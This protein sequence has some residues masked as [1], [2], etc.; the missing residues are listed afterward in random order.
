MKTL[1]YWAMIVGAVVSALSSV[2]VLVLGFTQSYWYLAATPLYVVL[3]V[4][5]WGVASRM[6]HAQEKR[7]LARC[8]RAD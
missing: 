4:S 3:A 1:K 5:L 2:L 6:R 7:V 8:N